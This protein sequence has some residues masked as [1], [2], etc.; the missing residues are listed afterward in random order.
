MVVVIN[1]TNS[2]IR[3]LETMSSQE[4]KVDVRIESRKSGSSRR[5]SRRKCLYV[6]YS[7]EAGY[8]ERKFVCDAVRQLKENGLA[9]DLWF[10]KDEGVLDSPCWLSQRLEAA[11]R[12]R[13]ALIF[14]SPSYFSCTVS[15]H[16]AA[17][18][19]DRQRTNPVAPPQL[20]KVKYCDLEECESN[21]IELKGN[22]IDLSNAKVS[23][24]ER[25]STLIGSFLPDLEKLSNASAHAPPAAA[26]DGPF[27]GQYK[28]RKIVNWSACD[29]QEWLFKLGIKE[30]YR[31][32]LAENAIDGFQLLTLTHHDMAD[33]LGIDSKPVRKKVMAQLLAT[34]DRE[35]KF[36]DSWHLRVRAAR[37]KPGHVYVVYDPADVRLVQKVKADLA[38]RGLTVLS[39]E[40]LGRTKDE[41]LEASGPGLSA[42]RQVVV[43]L[44]DAAVTSPFVMQ[45]T[46]LAT[47]LERRVITALFS[48]VWN[49][50]RSCL[51]AVLGPQS[52]VD[53]AS[54][55]YQDALAVLEHALKPA[56]QVPG[57]VL[58]QSYL[59]RMAE[60]LRSLAELGDDVISGGQTRNRLRGAGQVFISY[61]WDMQTKV[62][63]LRRQLEDAGLVCTA[64]MSP[65]V[66]NEGS[67]PARPR[68]DTLQSAAQRSI[69]AAS[70]IL[71]CVT[72]KYIQSD[73]CLKDLTLAE[74]MHKPIVPVMLRFCPWPPEGAPPPVRR[75]FARLVP[76]DLSNDKQVQQ[77]MLHLVE[78]LHKH[79]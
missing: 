53:F 54:R 39:H 12:C 7:A 4:G 68:T 18:L 41:F 40:R 48:P 5:S 36:K 13:A 71:S 9:D 63:E 27:T 15:R 35:F 42:A 2:N 49:E 17:L 70:V 67:A 66:R 43:V 45:E 65:S 73:S 10:D 44:S 3:T 51:R 6:S 31:Q 24:S 60:G 75:I 32:S 76:L 34:L 11:E 62:D 57:V 1:K 26:P 50:L 22:E 37:P 16:E 74:T 8:L 56:Q 21:Y 52:A 72:P 55:M 61:Q 20:F 38:D 30:F 69:R 23:L 58:E 47:W 19:V 46:L 64:D 25:C 29:V 77:N 14:C 79:V 78:R 28:N 59:Q 33:H